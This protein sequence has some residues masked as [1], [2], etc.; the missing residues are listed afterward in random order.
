MV[1]L[2]T[3][4]QEINGTPSKSAPTRQYISM[5]GEIS[6][7]NIQLFLSEETFLYKLMEDCNN[8]KMTSICGLE[9]VARL[10]QL[11]NE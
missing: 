7:R 9:G 10:S 5:L 3:L 4:W 8:V 6:F 1:I 11:N 2:I